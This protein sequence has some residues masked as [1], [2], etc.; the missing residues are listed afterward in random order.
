MPHAPLS[1]RRD[2]ALIFPIIIGQA[3]SG[4]PT[5]RSRCRSDLRK[6]GRGSPCSHHLVL[7]HCRLSW[8]LV[9]FTN[10][11]TCPNGASKRLASVSDISAPKS[12]IHRSSL[13]RTI[14]LPFVQ[15]RKT[16]AF[17]WP[18]GLIGIF[19]Q[20]LAR[21]PGTSKGPFFWVPINETFRFSAKGRALPAS[22]ASVRSTPIV[23]TVEPFNR[24]RKNPAK[25]WDRTPL[26]AASETA[27]AVI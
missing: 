20:L 16:S 12:M 23:S 27:G 7:C 3:T 24:V 22:L 26:E 14:P 2:I 5:Y 11:A 8:S 10:F 17:D 25:P 9:G 4:V 18:F 15:G 13:R 1:S 6:A 19:S 21:S